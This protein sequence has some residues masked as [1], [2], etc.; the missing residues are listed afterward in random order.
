MK[1][2]KKKIEEL[3][4]EIL[5]FLNERGIDED[6]CI[7]FNNKRIS[8]R[9]SYKDWDAPPK[10]VIEEDMCP[11]GYFEYAAHKHIL[12]MSFEGGLYD[13]INYGNG[14]TYDKLQAI[15]DKYG[16]YFELGHAWNLTAYPIDDDM[17]VEYTMY[18]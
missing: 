2:T 16:L 18:E 13:A 14:G 8:N 4:Y 5:T 17:Q 15:F 10:L 7:Y 9:Y 3:A 11:L 6:V 12:S 1:L